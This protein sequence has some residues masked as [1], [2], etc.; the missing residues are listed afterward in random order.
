MD[1]ILYAKYTYPRH[2]E[3]D[4]I[5]DVTFRLVNKTTELPIDLT[6][7]EIIAVFRE[8]GPRGKEFLSV[9]SAE[10]ITKVDAA[11]GKW[12]FEPFNVETTSDLVGNV[13]FIKNGVELRTYLELAIPIK[14]NTI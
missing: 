9:T 1:S 5:I 6:D 8:G 14:S 13:R 2:K 3:G 4:T 11:D 10:G 7:V 12:K